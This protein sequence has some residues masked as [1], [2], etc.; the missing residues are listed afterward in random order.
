MLVGAIMNM[1]YGLECQYSMRVFYITNAHVQQTQVKKIK[2][3]CRDI[4]TKNFEFKEM[5]VEW[6]YFD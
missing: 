2:L 1:D 6:L 3:L 4:I 5:T